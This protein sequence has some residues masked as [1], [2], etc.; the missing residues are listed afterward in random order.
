M[1]YS[2]PKGPSSKQCTLGVRFQHM[3][4]VGRVESCG[5]SYSVCSN[6]SSIQAQDPLRM[7]FASFV[8]PLWVGSHNLEGA[9]SCPGT[10]CER[11]EVE[12]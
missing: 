12:V 7:A 2:P 8:L 9:P 6:C 4:E 1:T 10:D 3:N 11:L 5:H